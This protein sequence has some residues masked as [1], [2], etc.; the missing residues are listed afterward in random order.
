MHPD[1]IPGE[2]PSE[3]KEINR[4]KNY[5]PDIAPSE[6][7][8][9]LKQRMMKFGC[10]AREE[11]SIDE[12]ERVKHFRSDSFLSVPRTQSHPYRFS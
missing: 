5:T 7:R 8:Q 4:P 3:H 12:T 11:Q 2:Y 6:A 9:Q 1:Y 10:S